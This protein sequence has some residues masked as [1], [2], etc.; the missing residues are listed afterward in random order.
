VL[1]TEIVSIISAH[2][3]GISRRAALAELRQRGHEFGDADVFKMIRQA[4]TDG[5]I[6]ADGQGRASKLYPSKRFD[7]Q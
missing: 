2:P 3:D 7:P 4:T 1:P 5:Y 6:V